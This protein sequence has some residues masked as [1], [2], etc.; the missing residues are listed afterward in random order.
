MRSPRSVLHP[1]AP[2]SWPT[3]RSAAL[4]DARLRTDHVQIERDTGRFVVLEAIDGDRVRVTALGERFAIGMPIPREEWLS[5][6]YRTP[7]NRELAAYNNGLSL[8]PTT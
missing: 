2:L 3:R 7:T 1:F 4:L 6:H 8:L 5:D